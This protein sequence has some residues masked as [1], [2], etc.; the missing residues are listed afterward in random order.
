MPKLT[1]LYLKRCRSRQSPKQLNSPAKEDGSFPSRPIP[2]W[3][4]S[5]VSRT[6]TRLFHL[7]QIKWGVS[8]TQRSR[9]SWHSELQSCCNRTGLGPSLKDWTMRFRDTPRR[10]EINCEEEKER[11]GWPN[12]ICH[13]I[14]SQWRPGLIRCISQPLMHSGWLLYWV[15]CDR[16]SH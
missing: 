8:W 1:I 14:S 6:N 5:P 9:F 10:V 13:N 3:S 15:D 11:Q 7:S 12:V 16:S 2:C 4:D